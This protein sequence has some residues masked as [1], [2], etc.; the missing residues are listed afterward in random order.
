M[1]AA[2]LVSELAELVSQLRPD[3]DVVLPASIA[4]NPS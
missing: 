1:P 3:D 4:E 2:E